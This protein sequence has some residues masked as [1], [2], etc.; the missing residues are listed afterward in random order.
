MSYLRAYREERQKNAKDLGLVRVNR[1]RYELPSDWLVPFHVNLKDCG[2]SQ[3]AIMTEVARQM[4]QGY[5]NA[6]Q[7]EKRRVSGD[8][9]VY[10]FSIC[11]K[12]PQEFEEAIGE[13]MQV[14]KRSVDESGTVF[15]YE[16]IAPPVFILF[17][18][19]GQTIAEFHEKETV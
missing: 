11:T 6:L 4:A 16:V 12:F 18:E 9:I 8:W 1:D 15:Q 7:S 17:V 13:D 3:L 2:R 19:L 14:L 10:Q 5:K